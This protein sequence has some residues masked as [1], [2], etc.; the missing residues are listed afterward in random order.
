MKNPFII[1]QNGAKV[2]FER[3]SDLQ[4]NFEEEMHA[5]PLIPKGLLGG[6]NVQNP[7]M[8]KSEHLLEEQK[9][10]VKLIANAQLN[11]TAKGEVLST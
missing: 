2:Q 4:A 6:E 3:P 10:L 1:I 5:D 11:H 8:N 7:A 9:D